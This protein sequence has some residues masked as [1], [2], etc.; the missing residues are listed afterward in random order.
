MTQHVSCEHE[1]I[2]E[3]ELTCVATEGRACGGESSQFRG[4]HLEHSLEHSCAQRRA[5]FVKIRQTV[6]NDLN[7]NARP[8]EG[9]SSSRFQLRRIEQLQ[10]TVVVDSIAQSGLELS[11]VCSQMTEQQIAFVGAVFRESYDPSEILKDI[12]DVDRWNLRLCP[13]DTIG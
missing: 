12:G 2:V 11:H 7:A 13:V 4:E 9:S 5:R 6:S 10:S 1:Q 8:V 3:L